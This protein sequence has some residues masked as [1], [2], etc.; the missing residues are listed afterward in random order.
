MLAPLGIL[1]RPYNRISNASVAIAPNARLLFLAAIVI[2][3]AFFPS[4][5]LSFSLMC[6]VSVAAAS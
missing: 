4:E 6:G 3:L 5:R 1:N 2:Y